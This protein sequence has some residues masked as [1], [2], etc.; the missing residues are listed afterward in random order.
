MLQIVNDLINCA[1]YLRTCSDDVR[2][3]IFKQAFFE[4]LMNIV[5]IYCY[6]YRIKYPPSYIDFNK[7]NS[8]F[9]TIFYTYFQF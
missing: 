4:F 5:P 1:C 2:F 3:I 6:V 9:E 7:Y 8:F